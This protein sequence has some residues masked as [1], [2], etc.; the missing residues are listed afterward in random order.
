MTFNKELDKEIKEAQKET[1]A[2]EL[3][4]SEKDRKARIEI[5]TDLGR[6]IET[7]FE[8]RAKARTSKEGEWK[9]AQ[10]LYDNPL[11]RI[12][13]EHVSPDRPF[14]AEVA[15]RRPDINI[16][17]TKCDIAIAQSISMQF[18]GG[19]K[20]WDLFPPANVTD[21]KVI[22]ACRG[23]EKEIES[24]LSMSKYGHQARLAMEDRVI[25]GTG[26]LKGPVNT[27]KLVTRYYPTESGLWAPRVESEIVPEVTRVSPWMFFPDHTVNDYAECSDTIELHPMTPIDLSLLREHDGFDAPTILEILRNETMKPAKYNEMVFSAVFGASSNPYLYKNRYQVLEYNGPITY[28]T[29]NKL[30]I[31]PVYESPTN[32]YWGEVWVCAGRVIRIELE[33]I[34][35]TYDT[36]Y[37]VAVWKKDPSSV[38]GF[39]HPLLMSDA[40]RVVTQVWHMALDN[41]SLASGPQVAMYQEYLQPAD[42]SWDMTPRKVWKL[43]DPS[44][45]IQDAIQWFS[46]PNMVNDILPIMQLARQFAEEESGT[47]LF[48]AGLG[49]PQNA[50]SATGSLIMNHNSNVVLDAYSEQWDDNITEKLINRY[51]HWNMQYNPK[52]EIKGDYVIDVRSSTEY[53]NKQMYV[54]DLEKL[55][56]ESI[57]NP[58]LQII[59]DQ[60]ELQ[61][62]RLTL[63]HLPN[64]R[65][66]RSD[67]EIAQIEQQQANQPNPEMIEL[68]IKQ[69]QAE[70]D[71]LK[72]QLQQEQLQFE[73]QQ[74]QQRE[75]WEHEEKMSANYARIQEA[76]ASVIRSQNEKETEFVKL[77]S[78]DEQFRLQLD[79]QT[80]IQ[81]INNQTKVFMEGMKQQTRAHDNL[82]AEEELKLKRQGKTGI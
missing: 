64:N 15:R 23:M 11:R 1:P 45:K 35:G 80:K 3:G 71:R 28:D 27:G 24:Q 70:T 67:E 69:A 75:Q 60:K 57:Q 25:L 79:N 52:P 68:Q 36:P 19:E 30:G 74:Q 47:P 73:R 81:L 16:V 13:G 18:A 77:A 38:F 5:L 54:R 78:K 9:R 63:M 76:Q 29:L 46:P 42:G 10:D 56:V 12:S 62:A 22:E 2:G 8:E 65:I 43:L 58:A 48:N 33:N 66:L 50:E 39:G 20:N 6:K 37:H 26:I 53:K 49:S 7:L 32:E 82:I 17:R 14:A 51:Y 34:Q 44:V 31:E 21:P 40:Q 61:K 55:S 59:I 72:L 41:A 4:E